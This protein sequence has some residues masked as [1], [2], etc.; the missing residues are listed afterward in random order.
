MKFQLFIKA[1]MLI[2]SDL[3]AYKL[4][5]VV[6][7]VLLNVRMS[8]FVGILTVMSMINVMLS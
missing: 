5:E 1:K 3:I 8:T 6:F 2:R 7:M 4:S